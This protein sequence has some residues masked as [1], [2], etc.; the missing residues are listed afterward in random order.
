MEE[1]TT[2]TAE[3]HQEQPE[4]KTDEPV[5][6]TALEVVVEDDEREPG[7]D[8][9]EAVRA[10][11]HYREAKRY[12][13]ELENERVDRIRY[14]ERLKTLEEERKRPQP[15]EERIWTADE[16]EQAIDEGKIT[17]AQGTSYLVQVGV[18]QAFK[19]QREQ[20]QTQK[21]LERAKA[22][23]GEYMGFEPWLRTGTDPRFNDVRHEFTR[24]REL[25]FADTEATELVAVRAVLGPLEK[26][27]EKREAARM[28]RQASPAAADTARGGNGGVGGNNTVDLSKAPAHFHQMWNRTSTPQ[29]IRV[30]EFKAWQARQAGKRA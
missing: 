3:E 17:R 23:L 22:E 10:R 27:R 20:E 19:E 24:L 12:K 4:V 1:E 13:A 7:G 8:S 6:E 9:P 16:I 30:K 28:T 14:E 21:P 5:K 29:E 26:L 11:K 18:K 25:G 2:T 15:A